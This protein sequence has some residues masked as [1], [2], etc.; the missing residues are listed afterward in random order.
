M[1]TITQILAQVNFGSSYSTHLASLLGILYI[2]IAVVY[3]VIART[4]PV[5]GASGSSSLTNLRYVLQSV[6]LPIFI[7]LSGFILILNG[8]KLDPLLQ[9]EQLLLFIVI[10]Y[11][12]SKDFL[13]I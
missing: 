6:A 13:G 3:L 10:A 9:L 2:A 8:W 5:N 7:L 4:S 11:L 1:M 12:I